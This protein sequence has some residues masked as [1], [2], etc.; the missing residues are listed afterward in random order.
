MDEKRAMQS[1]VL[2]GLI[3]FGGKSCGA[4]RKKMHA[5]FMHANAGVHVIYFFAATRAHIKRMLNAAL[6]KK[7]TARE[8]KR[9][10]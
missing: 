7:G 5:R 1:L 6:R 10:S 4:R 3:A 9:T 2:A 8:K